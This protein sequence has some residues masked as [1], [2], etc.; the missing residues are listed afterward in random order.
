MRT[1]QVFRITVSALFATFVAAQAARATPTKPSFA[2]TWQGSMHDL[3]AI[4][5]R[6]DVAGGK[7]GGVIV[8]FFQQRHDAESPWHV[9]GESPGPLL[10][11]HLDGNTLTF[12]VEHHKCH[13]CTELGPNVK[14]RME[15]RGPDEARLWNVSEET[16]S[17]PGP[18]LKMVRQA[19]T[20][21]GA[22]Q[23]L[24]K[25]ISVELA[26]TSHAVAMPDAEKEDALIVAVTHDGRVYFGIDPITPVALAEE[27]KRD[28]SSQTEKRLYIKADA[29]IP[30]ANVMKVLDAVRRA[31]V[32]APNLLTNQ[33]ETPE[34]GKLV[35][36]K[37]LEVLVGPS[38][39]SGAGS[40][41]VQVLN[42]GERWPVLKINNEDVPWATLESRLRQLFTSRGEKVVLVKADG[43]L[44]YA[45]IVHVID[46]CRSMGA[47]VFLSTP[48]T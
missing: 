11:P 14:F 40:T 33:P 22:A 47:E 43:P 25:G 4:R 37:G 6:L 44:P 45:R 30:Y 28:L 34:P 9:A 41:V 17:G 15:L 5:L 35:P 21:A 31:G 10:A 29:R 23:A 7:I 32:T 18:G 46:V 1:R 27:V 13:S 42:S 38:L 24:K 8:F 19:D 48:A 26:V 12:E 36:P 39:P 20:T 2:G 3:P 16:G